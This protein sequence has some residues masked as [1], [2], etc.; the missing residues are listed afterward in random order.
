MTLSQVCGIVS[1]NLNEGGYT[2]AIA[3]S[4]SMFDSFIVGIT[5]VAV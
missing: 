3:S 5:G 1:Q 4:T 2:P